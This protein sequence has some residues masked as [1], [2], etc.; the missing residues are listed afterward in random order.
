MVERDYLMF[1][2]RLDEVGFWNILLSEK[3]EYCNWEINV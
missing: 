3:R 1:L 2:K